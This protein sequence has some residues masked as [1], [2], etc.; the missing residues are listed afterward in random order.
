MRSASRFGPLTSSR[1]TGYR[2]AGSP[3]IK[4]RARRRDRRP[5]CDARRAAGMREQVARARLVMDPQHRF[6]RVAKRAVADVVQQQR[7]RARGASD[8]PRRLQVAKCSRPCACKP[9]KARVPIASAP[10]ECVKRECSADGNAKVGA[11]PS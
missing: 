4:S 8:T 5:S 11:S 10:R 3:K 9:S 2:V 1:R 6:A 7:R